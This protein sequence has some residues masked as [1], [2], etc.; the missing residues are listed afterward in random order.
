[1]V[2]RDADQEDGMR[3]DING[4]GKIQI[5]LP[6]ADYNKYAM[7]VKRPAY[8]SILNTMIVLP[9]LIW[10]FENIRLSEEFYETNKDARWL[11]SINIV[12]EGSNLSLTPESIDRSSSFELAQNLLGM[13][14]DRSLDG[15][16]DIGEE[17]E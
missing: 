6:K 3:V 17:I 15:L 4:S 16:S 7:L 2:R 5:S 9:A 1:M 14:L 10:A 12:L 13:P 8:E 11:K